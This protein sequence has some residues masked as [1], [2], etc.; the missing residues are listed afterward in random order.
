[1]RTSVPL[2]VELVCAECANTTQGQSVSGPLNG[3]KAP[4]IRAAKAE[5][6]QLSDGKAFCSIAHRKAFT[7]RHRQKATAS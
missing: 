6:W 5:G 7:A 4:M 3:I 2:W 1:M